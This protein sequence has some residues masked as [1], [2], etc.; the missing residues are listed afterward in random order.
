MIN[1]ITLKSM[2]NSK[3]SSTSLLTKRHSYFCVFLL[4]LLSDCLISQK[5]FIP[6][7]DGVYVFINDAKGHLYYGDSI[8]YKEE[9]NNALKIFGEFGN[10]LNIPDCH[11]QKRQVQSD[12]YHSELLSVLYFVN[13]SVAVESI[14]GC[15]DSLYIKINT[16]LILIGKYKMLDVYGN[17][18]KKNVSITDSIINI[19]ILN[20]GLKEY[21]GKILNENEI[22]FNLRFIDPFIMPVYP[23]DVKFN[24]ISFNE[25]FK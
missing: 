17:F 2:I 12:F 4:M 15:N 19:R 22:S 7:T 23:I 5:R 18:N 11:S 20:G 21:Y 1:T 14:W 8:S 6:R 3:Y 9:K 16:I 10:C 25:L 13:D 24:F